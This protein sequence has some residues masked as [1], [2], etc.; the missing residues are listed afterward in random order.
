MFIHLRLKK[1]EIAGNLHPDAL[2]RS[3]LQPQLI[4]LL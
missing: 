2:D 4:T 3:S 1:T